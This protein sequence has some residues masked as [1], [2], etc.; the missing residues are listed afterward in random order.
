[1]S[2]LV[3]NVAKV[4]AAHAAL[5]EAIASKGVAVPDGTKLSAMPALVE[6]IQTGGAAPSPAG[7]GRPSDWPRIDLVNTEKTDP[8]VCYF[9]VQKPYD[10]LN[11]GFCLLAKTT[12][13][14]PWR[15]DRIS[16]A[17][18]GSS[19]QAMAG[20][21]QTA[22]SGVY[23]TL[24][25]PDEDPAGTVYAVR[26]SSPTGANFSQLTLSKPSSAHVTGILYFISG[27]VL[28]AIIHQTSAKY[29][30]FG[31]GSWEYSGPRHIVY[32]GCTKGPDS[33]LY[34][35]L[36]D[37]LHLVE[38]RKGSLME[39]LN[40]TLSGFYCS[41]TILEIDDDVKIQMTPGDAYSSPFVKPDSSG[42][43]DIL[44]RFIDKSTGLPVD[45]TL[46]KGYGCFMNCGTLT[47][48][49]LPTGFGSSATKLNDFFSNCRSLAS[50]TLPAGFG[51]SATN[52]R[53]CFSRCV[54]LT[55]ISLPAGF[56]Q[57]ATNTSNCF[58]ACVSLVSLVLPAGFGQNATNT[59]NCFYGCFALTDVTGSPNFKTSFTLSDCANLTHDSLMVFING[60]QTVTT[61][62]KL[63]LGSNLLD[64][65]TDDEKKVA[66]DKGWTLA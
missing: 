56:G 11:H 52:I 35:A 18:D 12:D 10:T 54:T 2:T 61:T 42:T 57:N 43:I 58:N 33:Y 34:R 41:E 6:Q 8:D 37:N 5:K 21:E 32:T 19:V 4:T 7:W 40:S 15:M 55:S 36:L 28:E 63:T 66:T 16:V 14:N 1:M 3:E 53:Q 26:A 20:T 9:I 46:F 62:Q 31:N 29:M 23:I 22:N 17:D 27:V 48:L 39:V 49:T 51:S 30:T 60:L 44:E 65:L 24:Q 25:F 59:S 47:S 50:L 45:W 38:F 13:G 64:K